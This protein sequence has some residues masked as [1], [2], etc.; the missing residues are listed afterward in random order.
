MAKRVVVATDFSEAADEAVRQADE[1]ARAAGATLTVFHVIPNPLRTDPLFPQFRQEMA[2]DSPTLQRDVIEQVNVRV[3]ALTGRQPGEFEVLVEDGPPHAVIVRRAEERGADLVV[4]GAHGATGLS[5]I[6][7][8]SVAERVVRHAHCPVLV[9]RRSPK[10]RRVL[11]ATDF[12][13]PSLPAVAAAGEEARRAGAQLTI[14]HSIDL[15]LSLTEGMPE[16]LT[17]APFGFSTGVREELRDAVDG[18]LASALSRYGIDGDRFVAFGP[19]APA[20]LRHAEQIQA[21]LI[22]VGTVGRTGLPR[23]L[24]G[25][26]TEIVVRAAGCSVLVVRLSAA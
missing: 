4:V 10:S 16:P 25:S 3:T 7:L 18:K 8:G 22:V 17:S 11:V 26:V 12:S 14:F 23:L 13:D 6:L 5:R 2:D 15:G 19:A 1:R 20:I 24:L 9:A 21:Q